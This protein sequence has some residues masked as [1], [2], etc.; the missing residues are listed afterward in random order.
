MDFTNPND[1]SNEGSSLLYGEDGLQTILSKSDLDADV[2]RSV[3]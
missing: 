1:L 3:S 2:T